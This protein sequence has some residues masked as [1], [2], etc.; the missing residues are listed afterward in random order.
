MNPSERAPKTTS[1]RRHPLDESSPSS[2]GFSSGALHSTSYGWHLQYLT[3]IGITLSTLCFVSGLVADV[4]ASYFFFAIKNHVALAAAPLEILISILYWSL[5]AVD[6]SLVVSPDLP[7]LPLGTDIGFHLVPA[8]VLT[9]DA[10]FFSPPWP[11]FSKSTPLSPNPNA[12]LVT[13]VLSSSLA[14]LYWFWIELCYTHNGFYPYPLFTLLSTSQRVGLFTVS[15]VLMW[16]VGAG[17]RIIYASVNGVEIHQVLR[18]KGKKE[19]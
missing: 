7:M 19:L 11:S 13:L 12:S 4:T 8:V 3:I 5:R 15:G 18:H 2:R 14:F 17:L 1:S 10:I 9:L 6:P 16:L